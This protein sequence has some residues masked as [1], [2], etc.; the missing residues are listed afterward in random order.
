MEA[1]L[2]E[3]VLEVGYVRWNCDKRFQTPTASPVV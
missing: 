2:R 3:C 1:Y